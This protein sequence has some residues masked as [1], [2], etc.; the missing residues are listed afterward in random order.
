LE[1][2]SPF[3]ALAGK[4]LSREAF[5]ASEALEKDEAEREG[6]GDGYVNL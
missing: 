6:L 4:S 5:F 1:F 2:F 3:F